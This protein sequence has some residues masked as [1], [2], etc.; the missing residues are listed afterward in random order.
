L[1]GDLA[2]AQSLSAQ[3][4]LIGFFSLS[5]AIEAKKALEKCYFVN[6]LFVSRVLKEETPPWVFGNTGWIRIQGL[7]SGSLWN[8]QKVIVWSPYF[9]SV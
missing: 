9:F 6:H 4:T 1:R 2:F 3:R 7:A 8:C 5:E